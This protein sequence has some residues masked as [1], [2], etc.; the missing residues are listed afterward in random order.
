MKQR[1]GRGFSAAEMVVLWD[2]WQRGESKKAPGYSRRWPNS[3]I[4]PQRQRDLADPRGQ[5]LIRIGFGRT[6]GR[7][8]DS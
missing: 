8:Y 1:N 4:V 6:C 5:V 2:M 7:T 3:P